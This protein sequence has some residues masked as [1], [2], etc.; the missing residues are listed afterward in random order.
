MSENTK[1]KELIFG[2]LRELNLLPVGALPQLDRMSGDGSDRSFY[3]IRIEAGRSL[4]GVFPSPTSARGMEEQA[5]AF[6]IGVH[7]HDK[8]VPVPEIAGYDKKNGLL[9]FEDLGN[10]HLQAVV[11][12]ARL[13]AEVEPLYRQAIDGLIR[14]QLEGAQNFDTRFCWDTPRYDMPLM[15][16]RES[17][18]FRLSFCRD[19]MGRIADDPRLLLELQ[20]IARRAALEPA[21]YL[22]HRDFQSRN[23]LVHGGKVHII[24]YQ[25]ARLGPLGYD[26][27]SLLLDPYAGLSLESQD[28][29]YGYYC[30]TISGLL[31]LDQENFRAGYY[32]LALQRN[33]QILGAFAFLSQIKGKI[34]FEQFILPAAGSLKALL[35]DPLGREY[36]SLAGLVDELEEQLKKA[37]FFRMDD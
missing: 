27:A 22:L 7:L 17:D 8:V 9:L 31:S 18:Y 1:E 35:Q 12:E 2:L 13:F 20:H 28:V 23:L 14:F 16:S 24:D 11:R 29:L 5:A 10:L 34:F 32:C 25:G 33:L 37:Q 3:R 4:I 6:R 21:W 26:L 36:L 30:D 15:L 19:Y